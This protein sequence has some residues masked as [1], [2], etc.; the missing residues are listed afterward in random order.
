MAERLSML[1]PAGSKNAQDSS[2]IAAPFDNAQLMIWLQGLALFAL[3]FGIAYALLMSINGFVSNDDYYH[4]RIATQIIDQRALHVNFPW[5]PLTLL[6]PDRFVD[7]HLL[8]HLYL[9]PW[10]YWGGIQGA[11]IAQ[12]LVIGG[13]MVAFWSLLRS[14]KVQFAMIWT[15]ALFA[16]SIP[17]VYRL[18]MIRTQAA[19][20][21]LIL[22][23]LRCLFQGRY[24]WLIAL[25]FAFTWLY[26]GF[27]L[28]PII[29]GLYCLTHSLSK[30]RMIWQPLAFSVGGMLLGLIINPYF[31][32]N[33]AF[34]VEHLG[35]KVDI[36]SSIRVGS[37]WYP[38]TTAVLLENSFGALL[39]LGFGILKPVLRKNT[40]DDIEATALLVALLTLYMTFESR[41]FIEYFPPFALL[42]CAVAWGRDIPDWQTVLPARLQHPIITRLAPVVI[43]IPF[44]F[45]IWT[46]MNGAYD[47]VQGAEDVSYLAGGSQWLKTHAEPGTMIF[48]TDWDDFTYLFFNNTQNNYLV[49][50]DP[51][52]LQM[53]HP[54][55][56]NLWVPLTQ[57]SID[58]PSSENHETFGASYVISDT[59]HDAFEQR[60]D[61]DPNMQLVYRDANSLVWRIKINEV[62]AQD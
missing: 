40:S 11:K 25:A 9:A 55:L 49:G 2:R 19:A 26:N 16:L 48:Q 4:A 36:E 53:A 41:R 7:H 47:D 6:S 33:I 27:V 56:W 10:T 24:R 43:L 37:E 50:L 23:A 54:D 45:L 59:H 17:F 31:P 14:V 44:A 32:Q 62:E 8:Y 1:S 38:Y 34:I 60:A 46:T 15:V 5:L 42:Y 30:R 28:L 20:V 35:A 22:I 3:G 61:D 39:A 13:L 57:G 52:Y 29:V 51:T 58:Q 21:L 12:A 18:L